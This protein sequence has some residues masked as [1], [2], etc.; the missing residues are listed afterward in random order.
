MRRYA[1]HGL[2][3]LAFGL[4]LFAGSSFA[5]QPGATTAPTATTATTAT[6]A[7][8]PAAAQPAV[9]PNASPE[10]RA[11][12]MFRKGIEAHKQGNLVEAEGYYR[13]AFDLKK[14]YDIAGNLGDVELKLGKP[15]DAAEHLSFTIRNFPLTGKPELRER[16]QKA[17]D[18]AKRQVGAVRISVNVDRADIFVDGSTKVGQAPLSDEYFVDPGQHTFEA[19]LKG[20]KS[21]RQTI[22]STKGTLQELKLTMI[23]I[24]PP[25]PPKRSKAPAVALGVGAAVGFG[26][27]LGLFLL[28]NSK[29]GELE[30]IAG[31]IRTANGTCTAGATLHDRCA[32]LAST[33]KTVNTLDGV[34]I[35]AAALGG[36]SLV[37]MVVYLALP[38]PAPPTTRTTGLNLKLVPTAG[39]EGGGLLVSGSF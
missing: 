30:T 5:Q 22:T 4:S 16:M 33:K 38:N 17:L 3:S 36:L 31:E 6:T 25:P 15:R 37:G 24:A 23:A 28:S 26:A 27:G 12:A 39:R 2:A 32:D 8:A 7:P 35:G 21:A 1:F 9:D 11:M 14:S 18:E 20:Y 34:A 10:E 29:L 19:R 13:T